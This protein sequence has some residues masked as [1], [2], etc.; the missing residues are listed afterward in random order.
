M[1]S[2]IQS[3]PT[4]SISSNSSAQDNET[5]LL[6]ALYERLLKRPLKDIDRIYLIVLEEQLILDI[7]VPRQ[8]GRAI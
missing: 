3:L 5:H 7:L 6:L 8:L 1:Q 4:L 2:K